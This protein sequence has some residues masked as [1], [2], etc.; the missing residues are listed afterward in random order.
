MR[1]LVSVR[2]A[3]EAERAVAGGA[4]IVDAKEPA[5]GSIGQVSRETLQAIRRAVPPHQLLSVALGDVTENGSLARAVGAVSARVDYVKLGFRGLREALAVARLVERAVA[6][7]QRLPGRPVVIAVAYADFNRAASLPPEDVAGLL[8][9][10]GAG[11]L[12]VDTCFKDEGSL[13]HHITPVMLSVIAARLA[14]D[15]KLLALGGSLDSRH[16]RRA[17]DTGAAILGV[18][19]AA[20]DGGRTGVVTEDRVRALA[21][22]LG[23]EKLALEK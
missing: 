7:A 9:A 22:A 4:E 6:L 20:S 23:R 15:G 8:T 12:L 14:A 10:S 18:R 2:S 16:V 3:T 17:R 5:A 21:A 13:F 1:L 11:G 19:G